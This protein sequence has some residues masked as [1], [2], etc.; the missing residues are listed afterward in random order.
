MGLNFNI[1]FFNGCHDLAM[2]YLNLSGIAIITVK[3]VDYCCIIHE[4]SKYETIHLL[5][6][7]VFDERGYI[8]NACQIIQC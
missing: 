6:N 2:F 7:S 1:L 8:Q 4:I 5:E 3:V